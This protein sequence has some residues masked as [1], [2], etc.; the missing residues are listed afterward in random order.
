[1]SGRFSRPVYPGETLVVSIWLP[2]ED[3]GAALFQTASEDGTVVID[4]GRMQ[5]RP[6]G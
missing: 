4:H 2:D 6:P 5:F 3:G 1:M